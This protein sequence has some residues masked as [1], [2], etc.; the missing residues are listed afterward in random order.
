MKPLGLVALALGA[1]LAQ[2]AQQPRFSTSVEMV[3]L[4]VDVMNDQGAI[5]GLSARDFEVTDNGR[6]QVVSVEE[7]V[8]SP[9]DLAVVAQPLASIAQIAPGQLALISR[10]MTALEEL[11]EERDRVSLTVASAPPARLR[12]L[13]AGPVRFDETVRR[14]RTDAAVFDAMVVALASI[15]EKT[16]GRRRALL[17]FTN[18][19][20]FRSTVSFDRL[21]A[22]ARR[23]G[24]AFALVGASVPIREDIQAVAATAMGRALSDVAI[25]TASGTVFPV[26]LRAL[27][28]E[29][30]GVTVNLSDG[31]PHALME[32]TLRRLRTRYE[33]SYPLPPGK[34]WHDVVVKVDRRG[35][36]VTARP[37]YWIE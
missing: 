30:G 10:A 8:D 12:F 13:E 18:G 33:V 2:Q 11:V 16:P 19:A 17:A 4:E 9:L 25:A 32:Q 26:S 21:L 14:G 29:S 31:D 22:L 6:R 36:T 1:A 27:A 28:K 15:V 35:A 5:L 24:P 20:D 3:R 37:G 7:L 23:V 34:G